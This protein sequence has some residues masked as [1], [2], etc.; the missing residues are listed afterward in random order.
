ML[1]SIRSGII[2]YA[3][4]MTSSRVQFGVFVTAL[5]F[6]SNGPAA[7]LIYPEMFSRG[8]ESTTTIVFGFIPV[9]LNYCHMLCHLITGLIGLVAVTRRSWA[10]VYAL[11]GGTY[12]IAWGILGLAGG[13]HVRHHLGV[14]TFGSWVHVVEGTI[15]FV[16]FIVHKMTAQDHRAGGRDARP[17][18]AADARA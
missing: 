7:Y 8:M 5:W 10:V 15:L 18:E 2:R 13:D 1:L 4:A 6:T 11:A 14:D 12:Y 17:H 16:V 9:T 3:T